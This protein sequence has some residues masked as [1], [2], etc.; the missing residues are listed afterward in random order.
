MRRLHRWM[1]TA[2]GVIT[3]AVV[4]VL[5]TW[6]FLGWFAAL[7]LAGMLAALGL[8]DISYRHIIGSVTF[9]ETVFQIPEGTFGTPPTGTVRQTGERAVSNPRRNVWNDWISSW[10]VVSMPRFQI[11][12]GTFGTRRASPT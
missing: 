8:L 5:I 9:S 11:P 4:V 1:S 2:A 3:L 10:L 7:Q 6:I 12:E